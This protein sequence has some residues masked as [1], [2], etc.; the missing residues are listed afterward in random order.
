[1]EPVNYNK[2]RYY[3]QSTLSRLIDSQEAHGRTQ[4]ELEEAKKEIEGLKAEIAALLRVMGKNKEKTLF[5]DE[6]E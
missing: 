3:Q 2:G 6:D 1:V 5:K 4:K